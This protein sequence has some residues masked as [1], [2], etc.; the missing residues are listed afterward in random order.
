MPAFGSVPCTS[1]RSTGT[2]QGAA[3]AAVDGVAREPDLVVG[4][5]E[6]YVWSDDTDYTIPV[7]AEG[8]VDEYGN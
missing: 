4:D 7:H 1:A 2:R 5:N 6:P 8:R 3:L